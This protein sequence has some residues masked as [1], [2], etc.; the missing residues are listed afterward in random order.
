MQ[1]FI[2]L[3]IFVWN[4]NHILELWMGFLPLRFR[5]GIWLPNHRQVVQLEMPLDI[6]DIQ[7]GK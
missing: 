7:A 2:Q 1:M 6:T 5:G 4:L 3:L